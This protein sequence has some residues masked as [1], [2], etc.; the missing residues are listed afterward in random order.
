MKRYIEPEMIVYN[1]GLDDVI[2]TSIGISNAEDCEYK[3]WDE[4]VFQ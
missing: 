2:A 4:I 1:L 3:S